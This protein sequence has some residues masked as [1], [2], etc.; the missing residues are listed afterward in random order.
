MDKI[1]YNVLK[2]IIKRDCIFYREYHTSDHTFTHCCIDE[3]DKRLDNCK[4][5]KCT[6]EITTGMIIR[7]QVFGMFN[8]SRNGRRISP[9]F[10]LSNDCES[11]MSWFCRDMVSDIGLELEPRIIQDQKTGKQT[12]VSFDLCKEV[13]LGKGLTEPT[14]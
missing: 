2:D 10:A 6:K 4:C 12:I 13:N 8:Q 14:H 9:P 3:D 5:N 1:V 11:F 7:G